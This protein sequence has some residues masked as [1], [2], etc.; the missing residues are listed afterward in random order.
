M[1]F[2]HAE[3]INGEEATKLVCVRNIGKNLLLMEGQTI[4]PGA[5]YMTEVAYGEIVYISRA[6]GSHIDPDADFELSQAF[7]DLDKMMDEVKPGKY[8]N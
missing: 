7:D 2:A 1:R 5:V 3:I 8:L 6:D 4:P